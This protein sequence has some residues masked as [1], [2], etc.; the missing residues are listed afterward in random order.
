MTDIDCLSIQYIL[1]ETFAY[2]GA[3]KRILLLFE[4]FHNDVIQVSLWFS[5]TRRNAQIYQAFRAFRGDIDGHGYPSGAR[6]L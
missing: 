4:V 2:V 1:L 3:N 5:L 6:E